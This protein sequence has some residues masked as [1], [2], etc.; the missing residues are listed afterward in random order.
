M[1]DARLAQEEKDRALAEKL[2]QEEADSNIARRLEEE[3]QGKSLAEKLEREQA[4][5]VAAQIA[6]SEG[7]GQNSVVSA[8]MQEAFKGLKFKKRLS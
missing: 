2:V 6:A 7:T 8:V 1:P 3:D 4:E 5:T